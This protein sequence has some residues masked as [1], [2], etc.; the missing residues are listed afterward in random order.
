V[1][2]FGMMCA[3]N[4]EVM[5]TGHFRHTCIFVHM[6]QSSAKPRVY[7]PPA[8]LLP[9][10]EA[11]GAARFQQNTSLIAANRIWRSHPPRVKKGGCLV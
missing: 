8:V 2:D 9:P 10:I 3:V 5:E 11:C 4:G 1:K 7:P 6:L